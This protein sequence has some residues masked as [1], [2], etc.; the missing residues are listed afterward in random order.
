MPGR[1]LGYRPGRDGSTAG[2]LQAPGVG[3]W[4]AFTILN[5]L[6]DVEPSVNL[7]KVDRGMIGGLP[8][9]EALPEEDGA[10]P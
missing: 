6:R 2:F 10:K 9:W 7:V 4:E 8:E 5:S 3:R 1:T